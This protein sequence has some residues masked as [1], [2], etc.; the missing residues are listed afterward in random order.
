MCSVFR[1]KGE[2][3]G[4]NFWTNMDLKQVNHLHYIYWS[5]GKGIL[6]GQLQSLCQAQQRG[7]GFRWWGGSRG[8]KA[9]RWGGSWGGGGCY[10]CA[11]GWLL[12]DSEG[13]LQWITSATPEP[14][15]ISLPPTHPQTRR[16]SGP[17]IC[18]ERRLFQL[19]VKT[20]K[21]GAPARQAGD[22]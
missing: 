21:E 14:G 7:G 13:R 22:H 17:K 11:S 1:K 9:R 5:G 3:H 8:G 19:L 2:I 6:P 4:K 20:G 15:D 12:T 10:Q 18:R 16:C